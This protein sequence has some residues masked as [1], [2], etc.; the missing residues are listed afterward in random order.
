M[1]GRVWRDPRHRAAATGEVSS[2]L[3]R[4][5]RFAIGIVTRLRC[6][7]HSSALL[8]ISPVSARY[9]R[10]AVLSFGQFPAQTTGVW[11]RPHGQMDGADIVDP[12]PQGM[13]SDISLALAV[14][15]VCCVLRRKEFHFGFAVQAIQDG[16]LDVDELA[17]FASS[18]L[19]SRSPAGRCPS[20][21]KGDRWW[22][23]DCQPAC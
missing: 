19:S 2:S 12:A 1:A 17:A 9:Y 22:E 23:Y 4:V 11:R 18:T 13:R 7:E 14:A 8:Q 20:C 5:S 15:I 16:W 3:L 21:R 10:V 6:D